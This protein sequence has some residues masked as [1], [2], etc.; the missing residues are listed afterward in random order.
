M[1]LA[2]ISIVILNSPFSWFLCI[3]LLARFHSS[4]HAFSD[5]ILSG[6]LTGII[7]IILL[8][9]GKDE[10]RRR[11][12]WVIAACFETFLWQLTAVGM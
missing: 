6:F 1:F 8:F 11:I 7:S 12:G 2:G 4:D 5:C 9:V 3:R 10:R